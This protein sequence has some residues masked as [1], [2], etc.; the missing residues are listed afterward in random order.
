MSGD[1]VPADTKRLE[2]VAVRRVKGMPT[3]NTIQTKLMTDLHWRNY[4]ET[5]V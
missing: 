1:F 4:Q 3:R 5:V 2:V